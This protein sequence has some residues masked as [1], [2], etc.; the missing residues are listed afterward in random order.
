M[1]AGAQITPSLKMCSLFPALTSICSVYVRNDVLLAQKINGEFPFVTLFFCLASCSGMMHDP[2]GIASDVYY[3]LCGWWLHVALLGR[4]QLSHRVTCS[5]GSHFPV[6]HIRSSTV[7]S[8]SQ[9]FLR[10]AI[11]V[12]KALCSTMYFWIQSMIFQKKLDMIFPDLIAQL[13]SDKTVCYGQF[14]GIW[15]K[16]VLLSLMNF[17]P[18]N[19]LKNKSMSTN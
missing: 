3:S 6:S 5:P 15:K 16:K 14:P 9:P 1:G 17:P 13:P 10:T 7:V 18:I 19:T 11:N 12:S 4:G 2:T 8:L